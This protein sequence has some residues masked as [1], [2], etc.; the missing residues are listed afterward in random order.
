MAV[1]IKLCLGPKDQSKILICKYIQYLQLQAFL[2]RAREVERN[3]EKCFSQNIILEGFYHLVLSEHLFLSLSWAWQPFLYGECLLHRPPA[4]DESSG[5]GCGAP[6]VPLS[7]RRTLEQKELPTGMGMSGGAVPIQLALKTPRLQ[8]LWR[9]GEAKWDT[10]QRHSEEK[11]EFE[12]QGEEL[13][14]SAM[15]SA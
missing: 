7:A 6:M 14:F 1:E 4:R 10:N 8:G 12:N 9:S 13:I 11:Q 5:E 15:A 2:V 3:I